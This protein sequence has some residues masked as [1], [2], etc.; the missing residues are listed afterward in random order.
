MPSN[1]VADQ[2]AVY[3][4]EQCGKVDV[5]RT[6]RAGGICPECG[7]TG[8]AEVPA[9]G[10]AI[11]YTV[12]DRRHG[13]SV[14]DTRLG[15][16]AYFAGWM[17]LLNV[18]RC[19]QSQRTA[20]QRGGVPSR[21]GEVAVA[22]GLLTEAQVDALLRVQVI[23]NGP[24]QQALALGAVAV[25][26]GY[27][28]QDQLDSALA[29]QKALLLKYQEAP[30]LG[31][32][33]VEKGHLSGERVKTILEVQA[34]QGLGPLAD[35]L[36][37]PPRPGRT[38]ARSSVSVPTRTPPE[39]LAEE[40]IL[41]QCAKCGRARGGPAPEGRG[42]CPDCGS[43]ELRAVPL[44]HG[45]LH[46]DLRAPGPGPSVEDTRLG[47]MAFF[48]GWMS[49]EQIRECLAIQRDAAKRRDPVPRF[50]EQAV[51]LGYLQP[52]QLSG[53]LRIQN[54][55]RPPDQE[56]VFGNLVVRQDLVSREDLDDCLAEQRRM[57]WHQGECPS[58]GHLLCE[59]GLLN[60]QQVIDILTYQAKQGHGLLADL[61]PVPES[62]ERTGRMGGLLAESKWWVLA[63]FLSAAVLSVVSLAIGWL[64]AVWSSS[65]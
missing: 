16:T 32:L 60:E 59:K 61:R 19:L 37:P 58:L 39:A 45:S 56:S 5:R 20:I 8:V 35:L 31:I 18:S 41:W 7:A 1:A 14:E 62:E 38:T 64:L 42:P 28:T 55:Y 49:H 44:L 25:R 24:K 12:A 53:L 54:M 36:E 27:I 63:A 23:H 9:I 65:R 33:L 29:L 21:F 48:A 26:E 13:P 43:W 11:H 3:R 57:L 50:G 2:V 10:G 52:N 46:D 22:E 17:G 15:R 30:M 40:R 47:R 34:E 51:K 4:C 6:P